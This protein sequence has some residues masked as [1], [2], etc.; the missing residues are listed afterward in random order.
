MVRASGK[1]RA[2]VREPR[3]SATTTRSKVR[4]GDRAKR[5][6]TP[7]GRSSRPVIWSPNTYSHRSRQARR[8]STAATVAPRGFACRPRRP[9]CPRTAAGRARRA[10]SRP[11]RWRRRCPTVRGEGRDDVAALVDER[12]ARL[13]GGRAADGVVEAHPATTSRAAPRTSMFCPVSRSASKRSTTVVVQPAAASQWARA[14]RRCSL[15]RSG[16]EDCAS[17]G[18]TRS[19]LTHCD[20]ACGSR[21]RAGQDACFRVVP[22]APAI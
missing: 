15:R 13:P 16:R 20:L 9:G 6:V 12:R 21:V 3:P 14:V 22:W 10:G 17:S 1:V 2:R 19:G 4:S 7:S 18:R 5:T 11:P 8:L